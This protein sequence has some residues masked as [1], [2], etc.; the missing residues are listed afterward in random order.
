MAEGAG[1]ITASLTLDVSDFKASIG[2]AQKSLKSMG[3]GAA[4]SASQTVDKLTK[5]T[6][7]ANQALRDE[8]KTLNKISKEFTTYNEALRHGVV[9]VDQAKAAHVKLNKE[10]VSLKSSALETREGMNALYGAMSKSQGTKNEIVRFDQLSS[11]MARANQAASGAKTSLGAMFAVMGTGAAGASR[12]LVMSMTNLTESFQK[13]MMGGRQLRTFLLGDVMDAFMIASFAASSFGAMA[14]KA[15]GKAAK[16]FSFLAS[17]FPPIMAALTLVSAALGFF[18]FNTDSAKKK[19]KEMGDATDSAS[20]SFIRAAHDLTVLEAELAQVTTAFDGYIARANKAEEIKLDKAV[21][22]SQL[23]VKTLNKI[24]DIDVGP[25]AQDI[26]QAE[27]FIEEMRHEVGLLDDRMASLSGMEGVLHDNKEVNEELEKR[28]SILTK[29]SA[30]ES[31]LAMFQRQYNERG[32]ANASE[33]GGR[34]SRQKRVVEELRKQLSAIESLVGDTSELENIDAKRASLARDTVKEEQALIELREK[35]KELAAKERA[36]K[37]DSAAANLIEDFKRLDK[38]M[39]AFGKSPF[40]A[41]SQQAVKYMKQ[42]E[43]VEKKLKRL[44]KSSKTAAKF[45]Q[46]TEDQ[47]AIKNL[48]E[49]TAEYEKQIE[50][51]KRLRKVAEEGLRKTGVETKAR[52]LRLG[53]DQVAPMTGAQIFEQ[54]IKGKDPADEAMLARVKAFKKGLEDLG[55]STDQAAQALRS[56]P[57]A[58][59]DVMVAA[60]QFADDLVSGVGEMTRGSFSNVLAMTGKGAGMGIAAAFGADPETGGK[61]GEALGAFSDMMVGKIEVKTNVVDLD[62]NAVNVNMGELL[63]FEFND[64]LKQGADAFKP[65]ADVVFHLASNL[66]GLLAMLSNAFAPL[67]DMVANVLNMVFNVIFMIFATLGPAFA[68]VT[69]ALLMLSPV[70]EAAAN[71]VHGLISAVFGLVTMVLGAVSAIASMAIQLLTV[72]PVLEIFATLLNGFSE[73]FIILADAFG[74]ATVAIGEFVRWV[75]QV[76]KNEG[77]AN[78]GQDLMDLAGDFLQGLDRELG[79]FGREL[80]ESADLMAESNEQRSK[81]NKEASKVLNAP[82]GFKIEKYRYEAM[83]RE[84]MTNPYTGAPLNQNNVNIYGAVTVIADSP[85]DFMTRM[86]NNANRVGSINPQFGG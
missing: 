29:L 74:H 44:A 43:Q 64:Q 53:G 70:V 24:N 65:L 35:Q 15:T 61:I 78:M 8:V 58:I 19:T 76:T 48:K 66:G 72:V 63:A 75:G 9:T 54:K 55:L 71:F 80:Q 47:Q 38:M 10:I 16:A 51:A 41:D 30:Q 67:I 17:K 25:F 22:P 27:N 40:E 57:F 6:K 33:L 39:R 37:R 82:K 42:L 52:P 85:E 50:A 60:A 84:G 86:Q 34:L 12:S 1:Q 56:M 20:K 2:M 79:P 46:Q 59:N 83:N 13:G 32:R 68:L 4:K 28:N 5:S 21:R 81:A 31:R 26:A 45:V 36:R 77:L 73:G 14:E 62:G 18:L 69:G 49:R 23:L 11:Q 3:V 7:S